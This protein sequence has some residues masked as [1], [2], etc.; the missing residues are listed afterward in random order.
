MSLLFLELWKVL[1]GLFL[2]D[3][4][5]EREIHSEEV[6]QNLEAGIRVDDSYQ[7]AAKRSKYEGKMLKEKKV[8][9]GNLDDGNIKQHDDF[10]KNTQS[11]TYQ[12]RGLDKNTNKEKNV[13]DK[14]IKAGK[15]YSSC[16]SEEKNKVHITDS[17][18][19][20]DSDLLREDLMTTK[21]VDLDPTVIICGICR[22][23]QQT[24]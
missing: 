11:F 12:M 8:D 20:D 13:G 6:D 14:D 5:F 1:L 9:F 21:K 7:K 23:N 3:F 16:S 24:I 22:L 10:S 2:Y 4:F 19:D 15:N 18:D 17:E